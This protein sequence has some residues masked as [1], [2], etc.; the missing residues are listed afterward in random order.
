MPA[1][2]ALDVSMKTTSIHVT[3]EAGRCLWR[4]K[5]TTDPG[6]IADALI[7]HAPDLARVGLETGSWTTWL[8][9]GL[10]DLGLP[11]VC[12]DAR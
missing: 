11:V 9:H 7:E 4:G 3:D 12:M 5:A 2:A 8:Y 10:S 6:S 1:F